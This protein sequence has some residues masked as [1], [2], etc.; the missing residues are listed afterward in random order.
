MSVAEI[1]AN[2]FTDR[3]QWYWRNEAQVANGPYA[4][5]MDAL[6]GL[7]AYCDKRTRWEKIKALLWEIW[8]S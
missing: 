1:R 8:R 5:Q 2:P 3:G 6:R 7:L 4:S